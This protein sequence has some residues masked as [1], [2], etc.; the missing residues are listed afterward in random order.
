MAY[1][2]AKIS[3]NQRMRQPTNGADTQLWLAIWVVEK[4]ITTTTN[5]NRS[6]IPQTNPPAAWPA[7]TSQ[8][9]L[10]HNRQGEIVR[11]LG[12]C[13]VLSSLPIMRP[14]EFRVLPKTLACQQTLVFVACDL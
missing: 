1:R 12:R 11:F 8:N 6:S 4:E 13:A 5:G 7:T 14:S 3:K 2:A 10:F 9:F